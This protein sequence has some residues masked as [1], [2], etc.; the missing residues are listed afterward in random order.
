MY[1]SNR[2]A[3]LFTCEVTHMKLI[4]DRSF[5]EASQQSTLIFTNHNLNCEK[6]L[7]MT[8]FWRLHAMLL[9]PC[10]LLFNSL[11]VFW[12]SPEVIRGYPKLGVTDCDTAFSNI[13]GE[14]DS[15]SFFFVHAPSIK[16]NHSNKGFRK[17]TVTLYRSIL[18]F[19]GLER[20]IGL[21]KEMKF[22]FCVLNGL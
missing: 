16:V 11:L 5:Q 18:A 17:T 7:W 9:A 12:V 19:L 15:F 22:H 14:R 13:P 4:T 8:I 1:V 21:V 20:A 3:A 10:R 2:S 6:F